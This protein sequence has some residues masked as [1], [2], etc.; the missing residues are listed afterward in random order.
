MSPPASTN[1]RGPDTVGRRCLSAI[2]AICL[3]L[4]WS[5]SETMRPCAAAADSSSPATP[6]GK[7]LLHLNLEWSARVAQIT[8][9]LLAHGP[10]LRLGQRHV[11][12][13]AGGSA[14]L[15]WFEVS[16]EGRQYE[17]VGLRGALHI[18]EA[19]SLEQGAQPCLV[20]ERER[21][22]RGLG[23]RRHTAGDDHV[24][25]AIV[26]ALGRGADRDRSAS[27][28]A[29]DAMELRKAARRVQEEH[30]AETAQHGVECAIVETERL[31][32]LDHDGGV[33]RAGQ[34]LARPIHHGL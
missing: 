27:A 4:S 8:P 3:Q 2:P 32:V 11:G 20:T 30:Q 10:A 13:P 1:S 22:G 12:L 16:L 15:E 18:S 34:A 24:D 9:A 33:R 17:A 7:P 14:L 21:A 19:H 31:T 29:Q 25:P 28:G 26:R 5:E 6:A 23:E